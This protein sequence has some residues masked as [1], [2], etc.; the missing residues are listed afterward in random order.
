MC[1]L[2]VLICRKIVSQENRTSWGWNWLQRVNVND[3][4]TWTDGSLQCCY[5]YLRP[6]SG[7]WQPKNQQPINNQN[8]IWSTK[9]TVTIASQPSSFRRK[10][11][12]S[13]INNNVLHEYYYTV[14]WEAKRCLHLLVFFVF[15][16]SGLCNAII[17][18]LWSSIHKC[19]TMSG[20]LAKAC[21][22]L[23]L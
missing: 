9:Y 10:Q 11:L 1:L 21:N 16:A 5:V 4:E 20:R 6:T 2:L 14:K 3:R 7:I 19:P 17:C 12:Q 23:R 8:T 13:N 15:V 22:E 18:N